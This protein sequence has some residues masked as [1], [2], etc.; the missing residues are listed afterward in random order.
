MNL[1]LHYAIPS[2]YSQKAVLAFHEKGVPFTPAPVN[3]IDP[4]GAAAYRK[5][6]PLGKIPLLT[7]DNLFIPESTIIIE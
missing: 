1:I 2:T 5:L 6:Y 4:A 3:L 7:G